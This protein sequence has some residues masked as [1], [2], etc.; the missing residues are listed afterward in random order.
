M[1]LQGLARLSLSG[2]FF[3]LLVSLDLGLDILPVNL[4][5]LAVLHE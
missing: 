3:L 2:L 4:D 1:M 5:L